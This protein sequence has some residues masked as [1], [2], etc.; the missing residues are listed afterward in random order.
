M[1]LPAAGVYTVRIVNDEGAVV[2]PLPDATVQSITWNLNAPMSA[3]ITVPVH[4]DQLADLISQDATRLRELQV[5]R[6]GSFLCWLVLTS[7]TAD[8]QTATL[9]C[10]D[11][12]WYLGKRH[13]GRLYD[14]NLLDGADYDG[15]AGWTIGSGVT[16]S[17]LYSV[18]AMSGD[19][20]LQLQS[21]SGASLN[22]NHASK[23]VTIPATSSEETY[24]VTA[25]SWIDGVTAFT[26][27]EHYPLGVVALVFNPSGEVVAGSIDGA[28]RDDDSRIF[29]TR[30][31]CSVKIP[32]HGSDAYTLK[33]YLM[34]PTGKVYYDYARAIEVEAL[35]YQGTDQVTIAHAL[36]NHAQDSGIGKADLN[37]STSGSASGVY[38]SQVHAYAA[39]ENILQ[40]LQEMAGQEDGFDFAV[41]CTATTRTFTTYFP[42]KG[43]VTPTVTLEWG[44]NVASWTWTVDLNQAASA[45]AVTG[46]GSTDEEGNADDVEHAYASDSAALGGRLLE[47]VEPAPGGP[48]AYVSRM[49]SQARETLNAR[50]RPVD[51]SVTS[52]RHAAA[53]YADMIQAGTLQ[54]GDNVNVDISHGIV[55]V[56][57]RARVVSLTLLPA[58]EQVQFVV[59]PGSIAS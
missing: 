21:G 5:F 35:K 44:Q 33:V 30:K 34:S 46:D 36:V 24:V 1:T 2:A 47:L 43:A 53:D 26:E 54:V 4:T 18:N 6:D 22:V 59:V 23:S 52:M 15:L 14:V 16:A 37:I 31:R 42:Q 58:T 32:A 12:L 57:E 9:N 19:R 29:W 39:H 13:V 10:S 56:D 40:V 51:F 17:S 41:V 50:K 25:Y 49:E 55:N 45:V 48:Y 20:V 38:R 7:I 3:V 8:E 28:L 27:F 11:P